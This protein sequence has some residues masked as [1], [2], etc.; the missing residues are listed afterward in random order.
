MIKIKIVAVGKDKDQ[1]VTDGCAHFVKLLG[2]WAK[3]EFVVI[4]SLKGTASLS[5]SLIKAKEAE[6]LL[7][8]LP[9]G[10]I[11][12][13]SDSG[14]KMDTIA[15]SKWLAKTAD[16][17]GGTIAFL[18]GG[19]YGLDD[20]ILSKA[21]EVVSLSSLTFSHQLVRLVL[22]EQLYRGLSLIHHTDYHK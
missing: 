20:S 10:R 12:A 1:W 19:A 22:L 7:A 2:R 5:P 13:L 14:L 8:A 16:R 17:S 4:P 11:V 3:V 21:D 6:R 18:I 15:F 9:T